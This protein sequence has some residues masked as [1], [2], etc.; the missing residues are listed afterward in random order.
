[1]DINRN[2]MLNCNILV[3]KGTREKLKDLGKKTQ[4]YDDIIDE[5]IEA[6]HSKILKLHRENEKREILVGQRF[7][8]LTQQVSGEVQ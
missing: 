2:H 8:P 1:M 7:E 4:T 6:R 5:L 3:R